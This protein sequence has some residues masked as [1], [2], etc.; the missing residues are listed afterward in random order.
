MYTLQLCNTT[1]FYNIIALRNNKHAAALLSVTRNICHLLVDKDKDEYNINVINAQFQARMFS[2]LS[3]NTKIEES[4]L[5]T[6]AVLVAP[7]IAFMLVAPIRST[8]VTLS[9]RKRAALNSI[10]HSS[11]ERTLLI[12]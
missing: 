9:S 8:S 4:T 10:S 7:T 1:L 3:S 11:V 5:F 2:M 12:R 6:L